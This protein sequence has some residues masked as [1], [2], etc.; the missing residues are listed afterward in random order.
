MNSSHRGYKKN[1]LS[2]YVDGRDNNFNLIRFFAASLVILSHSYPLVLG[3]GYSDWLGNMVGLS[4]GHLAVDVFFITSGFLITASLLN[5]KTPLLFLWN[6]IRRIYPALIVSVLVTVFII[7]LFFSESPTM[8][9]L[10]N[11]Q[12]YSYLIKNST[13]L[14]GLEA[15]LPGLFY[16]VPFDKAVNGSLWTLPWEIRMYG[17]LLIIGCLFSYTKIISRDLA[18]KFILMIGLFTPILYLLNEFFMFSVEPRMLNSLRFIAMFF[19]G[20]AFYLLRNKIVLSFRLSTVL[21]IC[22]CICIFLAPKFFYIFYICSIG[23]LIFC[24]AYLPKGSIRKFNRFGDYSYGLYIYAFPIQQVVIL[25]FADIGVF[26]GA[27]ISF[28]M[29]L[30]L[31]I[32]SWHFIESPFLKKKFANVRYGSALLQFEKKYKLP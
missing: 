21:F 31:A 32:I 19:M 11:S 9:Y 16:Q 25:I 30:F 26:E 12:T 4:F 13:L 18:I 8:K 23:Y 15:Y 17:I 24:L 22:V 7:G 10:S 5:T 28:G 2:N 1:F 27:L 29:T 3:R 14:F 20:G 6:R